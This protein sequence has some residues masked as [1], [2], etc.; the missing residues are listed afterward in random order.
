MN[1]KNIFVPYEESLELKKLGFEEDCLA[2]YRGHDLYISYLAGYF[3]DW[4]FE[5]NLTLDGERWLAC[6]TFEQAF[7][8]FRE[9]HGLFVSSQDNKSKYFRDIVEDGVVLEMLD[10]TDL[11]EANLETLKKLIKII[12][13]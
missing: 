4:K 7:E 12:S 10:G 9:K 3:E 2:C 5:N 11:K 1:I 6:P 13:E 8:W